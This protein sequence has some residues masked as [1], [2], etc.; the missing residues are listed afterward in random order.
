M[1]ANPA[2]Q[3]NVVQLKHDGITVLEVGEGDQACGEV[4][5]GRMLEAD[6]ILADLVAFFTPKSLLGQ[7]VL[8]TA[9]P[10]Y[11]AIDPVRGITNLS[12]GKMGFAIAR[13]AVEAGAD[14]TL[15]AGPVSLPT[16]RG[17]KRVDVKSAQDMLLAG[18]KY[19]NYATI[20]IASAAVADWRPANPADQKLK[21][22]GT[23]VVP[24]LAF[25]ENPDILATIAQSERG[26]KGLS[27]MPI[28][29]KKGLFC[30]GFAAESQDLLANAQA[31]RIRKGVPLL[32]GN[33]GPATFGQD[34]NA[35]L[36]V[37]AKSVKEL[38]EHGQKASKRDLA[39]QL[40]AD[41]AGRLGQ[42]T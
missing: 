21:K 27:G 34:D 31:K 32:I 7:K 40:V 35:L 9:G 41:I 6:E 29:E 19:A 4:G 38:P 26:K 1:W 11:E 18:V 15:I 22:D 30:V 13:A 33:I 28:G 2:T 14:V 3:R 17:V 10:T 42:K 5:D 25:V 12:S 16:P 36:L 8:I 39:K 37:D 20:F 23:G 24:Q